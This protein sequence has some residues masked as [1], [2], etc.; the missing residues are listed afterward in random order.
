MQQAKHRPSSSGCTALLDNGYKTRH[1]MVHFCF[2]YEH[3]F[4]TCSFWSWL[5]WVARCNTTKAMFFSQGCV[6]QASSIFGELESN[7][8]TT[9]QIVRDEKKTAADVKHY[10]NKTSTAHQCHVQKNIHVQFS[11]YN[12]KQ[13]IMLTAALPFSTF[14]SLG[15]PSQCLYLWPGLRAKVKLRVWSSN[16]T[17]LKCHKV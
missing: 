2:N 10:T 4:F 14:S 1:L 7:R 3:S 13:K 11:F 9:N 16:V 8:P 17:K 6:M 15:T 5:T 12:A